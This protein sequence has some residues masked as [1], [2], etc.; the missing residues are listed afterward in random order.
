MMRCC[1]CCCAGAR[2]SVVVDALE[3]LQQ[4]ARSAAK[5]Q[6]RVDVLVEVN[7]GQDRWGLLTNRHMLHSTCV[8]R[9]SRWVVVLFLGMPDFCFE[10]I[11][12]CWR[13][14]RML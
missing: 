12:S 8:M 2:L 14:L 7:V 6:T 10:L 13:M 5:F 11:P 3:P 9:N 1:C 4:L